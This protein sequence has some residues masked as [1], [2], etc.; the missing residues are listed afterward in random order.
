MECT[1][2]ILS[3]GTVKNHDDDDDDD[4]DDD[5]D[6]DDLFEVYTFREFY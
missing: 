1:V 2:S 3:T 4:D 5:N 6:D